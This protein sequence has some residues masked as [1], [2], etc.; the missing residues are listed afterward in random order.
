M[1]IRGTAVL[2]EVALLAATPGLAASGQD[3]SEHPPLA[4]RIPHVTRIHGYTLTDD[5]FW[6]REKKNPEVIKY[7]EAENAY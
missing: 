3:D 5:Y 6:L 7:L 4:R 2:L 1:K